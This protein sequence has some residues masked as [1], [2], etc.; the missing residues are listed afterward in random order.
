MTN[1]EILNDFQKLLENRYNNFVSSRS[2]LTMM[3]DYEGNQSRKRLE[4]YIKKE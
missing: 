4:K 3:V 2:N 1:D